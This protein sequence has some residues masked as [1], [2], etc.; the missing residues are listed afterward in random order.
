MTKSKGVSLTF[1]PDAIIKGYYGPIVELLNEKHEII[2]VGGVRLVVRSMGVLM[3][4]EEFIGMS[5]EAFEM[6]K[7]GEVP[8]GLKGRDLDENTYLGSDGMVSHGRPV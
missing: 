6:V 5:E 7:R 1:A 4:E 8:K 2:E 3:D